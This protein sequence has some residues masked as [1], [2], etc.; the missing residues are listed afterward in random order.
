MNWTWGGEH[1]IKYRDDVLQNCATENF[2]FINQCH[3]II[4]LKMKIKKLPSTLKKINWE[5]K[6]IQIIV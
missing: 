4:P 3:Q 1:T 5:G 2:N 6:N